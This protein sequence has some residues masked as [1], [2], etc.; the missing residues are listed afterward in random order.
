MQKSVI[1]SLTNWL[2]VNSDDVSFYCKFMK[3]IFT[4]VVLLLYDLLTIM[5]KQNIQESNLQEIKLWICAIASVKH[6]FLNF[7]VPINKAVYLNANSI[8]PSFMFMYICR[9]TSDFRIHFLH[10]KLSLSYPHFPSSHL[11][12]LAGDCSRMVNNEWH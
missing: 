10:K 6:Q 9:S 1:Q 4:F 12:I 5:H 2:N 8:Q 3:L 7:L 11:V